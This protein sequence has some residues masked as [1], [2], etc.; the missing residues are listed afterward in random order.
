MKILLVLVGFAI[1]IVT[2]ITES[3]SWHN[4]PIGYFLVGA[5]CILA[6]ALWGKGARDAAHY[7]TVQRVTGILAN[8]PLTMEDLL[9]KLTDGSHSPEFERY[10]EGIGFMLFERLLVIED[11]QVTLGSSQKGSGCEPG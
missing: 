4:V 5:S 3:H 8:G 1:P 6:G 2:L 10:R 9:A 7:D 11:G